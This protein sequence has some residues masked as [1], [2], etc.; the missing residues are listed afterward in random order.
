MPLRPP[1]PCRE[2]LCPGFAL[3][4]TARCAVHQAVRAKAKAAHRLPF[5]DTHAWRTLS[6]Q[7]LRAN[8]VCVDCG[9]P[10]SEAD[11]VIP[12]RQDPTLALEPSNIVSRCR[13]C[14]SSRTSRLHSWNLQ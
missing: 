8:P 13:R 3:P 11:H 6:K 1:R 12:V 5:Y 7:T 9:G 10:A 14:H 4:G 2:P